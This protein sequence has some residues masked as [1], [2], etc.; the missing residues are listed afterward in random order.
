VSGRRRTEQKL[1][2]SE[3]T[4][5]S[6]S[7][8]MTSDTGA[9]LATLGLSSPRALEGFLEAAPDA[10]VVVD[11]SGNIVI[12]NQLAE[13]LFGYSRRE[14]LGMRIERLVPQRLREQHADHRDH[15]FRELRTRPMGEGREL[16]GCRKD[17]SEFPVEISLSPLKTETGTLV[18]SI[19]RDTTARNKVEARFRGFL[20]AAPDAIVV[21][22][23]EGKMV[24]LNTQAERL[25][26]FPRED[27]LGMP[28]ETLVP[29]R[30]RGRHVGHRGEFFADPRVRPM[31]SGLEL[32][33]LR[34]DGSE[35]P[36]E[37]SLSP[38]ETEEGVLVSAAIRDITERKLVETRLRSSLKEKEVL[39]KEIHH[40]V[41]NNL[42]I[43]SSMLH[44][45]MEKL[46]DAQAIELFQDSQNR[47][48]SIALFHE[49]LY[50]SRDLGRVEIAEYLKGLANGL[51]ATYGVSP[52]DIVLE[53]HSE[54]IPLGVDAAI[55]CGLI[56]NELVSNSLKHA[57]PAQRKGR[58]EVTLRSAGTDVVLDVADNGIGFSATLDFRNPSTLGLKLVAIFT[59]QLDGTM[60]LT[61]EA[62]TRFSL[63]FTPGIRS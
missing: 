1:P 62:G 43:V 36:V 61:R 3:E 29:E 23:R 2:E 9:Y 42:Q 31:G 33:G 11:R 35:F 44:L 48:R 17:G 28:V 47:V 46:S 40:R 12:V 13:G 38:I 21:V 56:V 4:F 20:E 49:K 45:Q 22:N 32:F 6:W 41:K 27:L 59:E 18:I 30:F 55:S 8:K 54:D 34:S 60:D 25:F 5:V 52:D 58:V 26:K 57:F 53:V 50:Q 7:T 24:I 10:I 16:S 14:L 37:I 51:F 39:L 15:Y 63:R 19:I